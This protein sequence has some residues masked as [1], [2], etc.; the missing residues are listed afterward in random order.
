MPH[1]EAGRRRSILV[2][3][4]SPLPVP[5]ELLREII[6][7]YLADSF[8]ELALE[9]DVK[10]NWDPLSSLLH[11]SYHVRGTTQDLLDPI[12]GKPD[13]KCESSRTGIVYLDVL[14]ALR[15]LKLRLF[16][17]T[18]RP[19]RDMV[20][21]PEFSSK[22]FP[23][24][25]Y[26]SP[27]LWHAWSIV[28]NSWIKLAIER[29]AL[30]DAS[31]VYDLHWADISFLRDQARL[32]TETESIPRSLKKA[33][34]GPMMAHIHLSYLLFER[35]ATVYL[36]CKIS[37]GLIVHLWHVPNGNTEK[38]ACIDVTV[39][40]V[41]QRCKSL[42]PFMDA[43]AGFV[44]HQAA[45]HQAHLDSAEF[46]EAWQHLQGQADLPED[47]M[48]NRLCCCLKERLLAILSLE[49]RAQLQT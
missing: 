3:S 35:T 41:E 47:D 36:I 30:G 31:D 21:V 46:R 29:L 13:M 48:V 12:L 49:Q 43:A 17:P 4:R 45:I 14:L 33:I 16:S 42:S 22:T 18:D 39:E 8:L 26:D 27:F 23:T 1:I 10:R 25:R 2:V 15:C 24:A 40:M 7:G 38:Q 6:L 44:S 11:T 28:A 9:T 37:N 34:F 19:L 32:S 20:L 5:C